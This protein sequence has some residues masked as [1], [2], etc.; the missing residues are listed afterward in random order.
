[1]KR[2]YKSPLL[3]VCIAVSALFVLTG[4][5]IKACSES[6][7]IWY[8]ISSEL[9]RGGTCMISIFVG[10]GVFNYL[11]NLIYKKTGWHA[12][13]LLPTNLILVGGLLDATSLVGLM[14]T[15]YG[16]RWMYPLLGLVLLGVLLILVLAP[17]ARGMVPEAV[18][19]E[20]QI[21]FI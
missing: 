8:L 17:A 12:S 10:L 11:G 4:F 2:I 19:I 14:I 20:I 7:D 5:A 6:A 1:M 16:S 9:M 13:D 21:S 18:N 3:F 15:G